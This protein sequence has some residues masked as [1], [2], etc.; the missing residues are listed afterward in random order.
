[1]REIYS[2]VNEL[3][4]LIEGEKKWKQKQKKNPNQYSNNNNNK[5]T[6]HKMASTRNYI[7]TG[8]VQEYFSL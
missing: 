1:M 6:T 8:L 3:S 5:K 4:F 7:M 2:L